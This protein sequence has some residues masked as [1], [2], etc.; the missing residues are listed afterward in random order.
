MAFELT[1]RRKKNEKGKSFHRNL[2]SIFRNRR[3]I[4]QKTVKI[5]QKNG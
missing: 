3:K 4:A 1:E 5:P 2:N